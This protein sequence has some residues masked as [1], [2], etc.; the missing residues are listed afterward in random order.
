MRTISNSDKVI[1][2]RDIIA[3]VQELKEERDA[4]KEAIDEAT[5]AVKE[6]MEAKDGADNQ[7]PDADFDTAN[8]LDER[9][10]TLEDCKVDLAA[11]DEENGDEFKALKEI[12][13]ESPGDDWRYGSTLI[14]EDYFVEYCQ[15]LCH[16]IGDVPKDMPHYLVIDWDKTADNL[17]MD[18]SE[19][20]YDGQTYLVR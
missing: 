11:W 6:A 18:Y 3:R 15:E 1:D 13:D 14:H 9:T 16:D 4:L 2:S 5:E 12:D 19:V 17:R 20:D 7:A 8:E 10:A